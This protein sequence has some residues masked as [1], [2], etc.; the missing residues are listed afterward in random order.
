MKKR[1]LKRRN[2]LFLG[3]IFE[4]MP[5]KR[6]FQ[7]ASFEAIFRA[8]PYQ[9]TPSIK[10]LQIHRIHL[11]Y[12][13]HGDLMGLKMCIFLIRYRVATEVILTDLSTHAYAML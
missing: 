5:F 1:P 10:L 2:C 9:K 6:R 7:G 8:A 11:K 12:P 13:T 4:K 3:G